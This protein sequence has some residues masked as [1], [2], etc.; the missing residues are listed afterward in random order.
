MKDESPYH[1]ESLQLPEELFKARKSL[2]SR[3]M[4][5]FLSIS[6]QFGPY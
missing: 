1:Q 2:P 3:P 6:L 4:P 5:L